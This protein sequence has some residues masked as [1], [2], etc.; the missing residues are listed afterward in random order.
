MPIKVRR[1]E[2]PSRSFTGLEVLRAAGEG[3]FICGPLG[4]AAL[5]LCGGTEG[6]FTAESDCAR[7]V[8]IKAAIAKTKIA[9]AFVKRRIRQL[10]FRTLVT[11][12]YDEDA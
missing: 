5:P 8:L 12:H 7:A 11:Y 4:P 1:G 2:L 6:V 3:L 9:A 10:P